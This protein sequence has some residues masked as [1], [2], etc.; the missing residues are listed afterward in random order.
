MLR[1]TSHRDITKL[2]AREFGLS[3]RLSPAAQKAAIVAVIGERGFEYL[4]RAVARGVPPRKRRL[5]PEAMLDRAGL[6]YRI[7]RHRHA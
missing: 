4:M 5:G 6:R 7:L 2:I 1:P 3:S